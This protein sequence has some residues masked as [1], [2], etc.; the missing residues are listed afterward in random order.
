MLAYRLSGG[1]FYPVLDLKLFDLTAFM[2]IGSIILLSWQYFS[3]SDTE[4]RHQ[5]MKTLRSAVTMPV[6]CLASYIFFAIFFTSGKTEVSWDSLLYRF[7]LR[8]GAP[9]SFLAGQVFERHPLL[10][11]TTS[12]VYQSVLFGLAVLYVALRKRIETLPVNTIAAFL[13]GTVAGVMCYFV[14]PGAGPFYVFPG[15]PLHPPGEI[16][17]AGVAVTGLKLNALPSMHTFF[18]LLVLWN[19]RAG[20]RKLRLFGVLFFVFTEMATLGLGEHYLID[21]VATLPFA[22]A[23]EALCA[24]G[25]TWSDPRRYV[26]F[27]AGTSLF[28][29]WLILLRS[30]AWLTLPVWLLW[31]AVAVSVLV[32]F[33]LE[34]RLTCY[35]SA[36]EPVGHKPLAAVTPG[37]TF[38]AA[39]A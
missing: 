23:I 25:I 22:I 1:R 15:W 21:L 39:Q 27:A 34:R 11:D 16:A 6:C 38:D 19:S 36:A 35:G 32:P 13:V 17:I 10:R 4:E 28:A 12:L 29:G 5:R 31:L 37:Q 9:W 24:R 14:I 33:L 18:A 8:L 3:A 2:G 7:D 30:L 20:G 26:A